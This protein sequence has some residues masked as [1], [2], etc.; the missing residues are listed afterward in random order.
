ME[1]HLRASRGYLLRMVL[2]VRAPLCLEDVREP[3][4]VPKGQLKQQLTRRMLSMVWPIGNPLVP[5]SL[6]LRTLSR[7]CRLIET[8]Q[9]EEDYVKSFQHAT[10]DF[11][12]HRPQLDR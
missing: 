9:N 6:H 4:G 11:P 1:E 3:L 12:E 10:R 7:L 2:T 5:Q 8:G